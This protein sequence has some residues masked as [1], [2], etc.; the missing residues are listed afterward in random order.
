MD[1]AQLLRSAGR[2]AVVIE[3]SDIVAWIVPL[4]GQESNEILDRL[5]EWNNYLNDNVPI[6]QEPQPW[7]KLRWHLIAHHKLFKSNLRH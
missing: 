5:I 3:D 7:P 1:G 4:G 2:G 6:F